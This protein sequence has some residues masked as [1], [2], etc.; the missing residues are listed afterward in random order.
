M[1]FFIFWLNYNRSHPNAGAN[2]SRM[3]ASLFPD[4]WSTCPHTKKQIISCITSF[5]CGIIWAS[6]TIIISICWLLLIDTAHLIR[7]TAVFRTLAEIFSYLSRSASGFVVDVTLM[8]FIC[9]ISSN[10]LVSFKFLRTWNDCKEIMMHASIW[11]IWFA[12]F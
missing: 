6:C 9:K 10:A 4:G 3:L 11:F 5:D 8:H 12:E 2:A 1:S 7:D